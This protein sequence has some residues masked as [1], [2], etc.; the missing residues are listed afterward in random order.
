MYYFPQI[1]RFLLFVEFWCFAMRLS[2]CEIWLSHRQNNI[3]VTKH[4][5]AIN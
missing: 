4:L 1:C 3:F 5:L 2:C